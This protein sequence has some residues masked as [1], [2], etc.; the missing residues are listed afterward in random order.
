MSGQTTYS[1][2]NHYAATAISAATNGLTATKAMGDYIDRQ[3]K[4]SERD[5]S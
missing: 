2:A 5:D 4:G 3:N 1:R